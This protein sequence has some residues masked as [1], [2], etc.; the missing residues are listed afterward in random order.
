MDTYY[1]Q[2]EKS[3]DVAGML[4]VNMCVCDMLCDMIRSN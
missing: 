3:N 1:I 4:L 2:T